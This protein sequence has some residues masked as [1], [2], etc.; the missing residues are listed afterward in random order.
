MSQHHAIGTATH[1]G[2]SFACVIQDDRVWD[3]ASLPGLARFCDTLAIFEAWDEVE[4]KFLAIMAGPPRRGGQFRRRWL[5]APLLP[6][7][8]FCSG[9]NYRSMW[10]THAK[11]P[12]P[13]R[14]G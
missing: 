9:A 14:K 6:R 3:I 12:I 4:R 1:R 13:P 5:E 10:R 7:Q 2:R 8:I 11:H